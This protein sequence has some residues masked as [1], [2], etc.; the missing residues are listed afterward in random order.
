MLKLHWNMRIQS[1]LNNQQ[2]VEWINHISYDFDLYDVK[3]LSFMIINYYET[4]QS[5][6]VHVYS[7]H[8]LVQ[9]H[10]SFDFFRDRAILCFHNDFINLLNQQIMND[11]FKSTQLFML[12]DM[13]ENNN[14][15]KTENISTKYLQTLEFS[16]FFLLQ[17]YLKIET[18]IML[19]HNLHLHEKM[20]NNTQLIITHLHQDCIEDCILKS[21]FDENIWLISRIKLISKKDDYSWV[22]SRKQFSIHLCFAMIINKLQEQSLLIVNIN[23]SSFCFSHEQLYVALFRVTDVRRLLIL[24]HLFK[25]QCTDN[26]VYSEILLL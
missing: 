4:S 21:E 14:V 8:D 20:C 13:I 9:A 3:S 15:K 17:M 16:E 26:V 12:I 10:T 1:S 5:F 11:F 22:L 6:I 19:L 24:F 25:N 23:L 2:F 18:L 7:L